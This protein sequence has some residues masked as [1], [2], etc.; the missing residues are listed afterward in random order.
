MSLL[1]GVQLAASLHADGAFI[2]SLHAALIHSHSS[3]SS[4][5]THHAAMSASIGTT[6]ATTFQLDFMGYAVEWS[7]FDATRLAVATAQHF[8]IVGQGKQYVLQLQGGLLTP[9]AVFDTADGVYDCS[10][11]ESI[12][13]HLAFALGNGSVCVSA[14]S[15]RAGHRNDIGADWM[16]QRTHDSLAAFALPLFALL[17]FSCGI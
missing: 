5:P 3:L 4:L 16:L 6:A 11:S 13:T 8:G 15:S 2:P 7:P 17:S 14:G 10:W 9:T 12:D 1:L